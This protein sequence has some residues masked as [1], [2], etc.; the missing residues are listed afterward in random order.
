M[1]LVIG[2][3]YNWKH[4]PVDKLVYLGKKGVWNQFKKIGD[5]VYNQVWCEVLEEDLHMI[6]ETAPNK[7]VTT[8]STSTEWC[9]TPELYLQVVGA[10]NEEIEK[11]LAALEAAGAQSIT[12]Y[13]VG[14]P[15][16][17]G[18][19]FPIG[20]GDEEEV[21]RY[22]EE[23]GGEPKPYCLDPMDYE[24]TWQ[25]PHLIVTNV[26]SYLK[27]DAKHGDEELTT[28]IYLGVPDGS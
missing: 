16:G 14:E 20:D 11:G 19:I 17:A 13:Y 23:D 21:S 28:D 6:E 8:T 4:T 9:A 1:K 7:V 15:E 12:F 22:T 5:P 24:I 27:W 2:G 26:G 3:K 18:F 10:Y 25:G